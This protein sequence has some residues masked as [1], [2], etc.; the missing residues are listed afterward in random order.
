MTNAKYAF[1]EVRF[2]IENELT[3]VYVWL[4]NTGNEIDMP[5]G[6]IGWHHKTFPK[7]K[8]LVDILTENIKDAVMWPQDSP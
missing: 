7:S 8:T 6:V 3:E 4:E 2:K 1:R 5:L